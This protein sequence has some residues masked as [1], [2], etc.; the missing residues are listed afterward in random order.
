[1]GQNDLL[2][3]RWLY[4]WLFCKDLPYRLVV[5]CWYGVRPGPLKIDIF[6]SAILEQPF[7]VEWRQNFGLSMVV[8]VLGTISSFSFL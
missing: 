6:G 3:W 1:M 2:V 8:P 4:P 7:V 5:I